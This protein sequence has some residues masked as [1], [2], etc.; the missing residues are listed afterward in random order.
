MHTTSSNHASS[1]NANVSSS[2][3]S[4]SCSLA[5]LPSRL[6]GKPLMQTNIG[7]MSDP[8]KE[9]YPAAVQTVVDFPDFESDLSSFKLLE[10]DTSSDSMLSS[11]LSSP[12]IAEQQQQAL[13]N[14]QKAQVSDVQAERLDG[15][16][17]P[18]T[19]FS[20]A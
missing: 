20:F 4:D 19:L 14:V 5:S 1:I 6:P 17:R 15:S 16:L 10:E 8:S 13:N 11:L 2:I 18:S 7:L 12:H 9:A 3:P